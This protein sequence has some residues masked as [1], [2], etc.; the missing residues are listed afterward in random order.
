MDDHFQRMLEPSR[1]VTGW[2]IGFI[3]CLGFALS[4]HHIVFRLSPLTPRRA[5]ASSFMLKDKGAGQIFQPSKS[6]QG[7]RPGLVFKRGTRGVGYYEDF[8]EMKKVERLKTSGWETKE[9]TGSDAG[10][11]VSFQIYAFNIGERPGAGT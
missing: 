8:Y 4:L 6:F 2:H 11:R 9:T 7:P 10:I 5:S 1:Y 3:W